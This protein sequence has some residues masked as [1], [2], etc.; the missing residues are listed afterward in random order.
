[1]VVAIVVFD[2]FDDVVDA[3][4]DV[5]VVAASVVIHAFVDVVLYAK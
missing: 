3:V 5:V 1:M 4:D 2:E